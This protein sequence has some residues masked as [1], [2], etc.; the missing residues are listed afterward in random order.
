MV[1]VTVVRSAGFRSDAAQAKQFLEKVHVDTDRRSDSELAIST[2]RPS[3]GFFCSIRPWKD[4]E[5]TID[6]R[7]HVPRHSHLVI[8]HSGGSVPATGVTGDIDAT[9]RRGDIILMVPDLATCSIDALQ[10]QA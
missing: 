9:D 6:Y 2:T 8:H 4:S 5:V 1:E 10:K 7:I 3:S